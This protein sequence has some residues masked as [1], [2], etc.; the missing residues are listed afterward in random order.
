MTILFSGRYGRSDSLGVPDMIQCHSHLAYLCWL[1]NHA[2][3]PSDGH[4]AAA[5]SSLSPL[6]PRWGQDHRMEVVEA[7]AG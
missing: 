7:A 6:Q 2:L 5:S 3:E 1:L 4:S